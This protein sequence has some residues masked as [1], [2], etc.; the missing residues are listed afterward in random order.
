LASFIFQPLWPA[1]S[2]AI[3]RGDHEWV[4]KTVRKS[5]LLAAAISLGT[6]LLLSLLGPT[7]VLFWLKG[8]AT[9]SM[10]LF[11]G[12]A[13]LGVVFALNDVLVS[14]LST[15]HFLKTQ[16]VLAI[17]GGAAALASKIAL[18]PLLQSAG[19]PWG[20]AL[21]Y[22]ACFTLPGIVLVY[23]KVLTAK[24]GQPNEDGNH[25]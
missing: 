6:G 9:P 19:A 2:E 16:V 24:G 11:C 25:L 21:G 15:S 4:R 10:L 1:F 14:I 7:V 8:R 5:L 12:F 23:K 3:Q 22:A 13:L 17:L 18:V 20:T